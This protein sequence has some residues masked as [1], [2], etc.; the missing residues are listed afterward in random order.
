M[1]DDSQDQMR[2]LIENY[3]HQGYKYDQIVLFL[4]K[5]HDVKICTRTLKR[6]LK[7]YGLKRRGNDDQLKATITQL[8]NEAGPLNLYI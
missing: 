6:K 4:N 7:D 2:E 8:M 3:F 5:Y 1:A